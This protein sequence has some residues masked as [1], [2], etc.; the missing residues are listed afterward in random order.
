MTISDGV[1]T[2]MNSFMIVA[3]PAGLKNASPIGD[4]AIGRHGKKKRV[5]VK[6]ARK[7]TPRVPS[8]IASRNACEAVAAKKNPNSPSRLI[9]SIGFLKN[10]NSTS[11]LNARAKNA[12]CVSPR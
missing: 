5:G 6:G 2:Q 12:E 3:A 8:T 10:S 9:P 7:A 11:P 4:D 1:Q